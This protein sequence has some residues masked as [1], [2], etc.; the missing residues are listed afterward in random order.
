ML[1]KGYDNIWQFWY[2]NQDSWNPLIGNNVIQNKW[3]HLVGIYDGQ[4]MKLYED[5]LLVNSLGVST[6]KNRSRP[7]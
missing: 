6:V 5:G 7:L 3:T 2:G 4:Q 1:Y